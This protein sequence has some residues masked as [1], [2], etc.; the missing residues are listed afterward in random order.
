MVVITFSL[1]MAQDNIPLTL[2]QVLLLILK[3]EQQHKLLLIVPILVMLRQIVPL[4]SL[5]VPLLKQTQLPLLLTV[6][7]H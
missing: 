4:H 1:V 5:T 2:L 7:L 3:L 6:A